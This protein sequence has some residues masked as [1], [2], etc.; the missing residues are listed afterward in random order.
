VSYVLLSL[1]IPFF[2]PAGPEA[3]KEGNFRWL[4]DRRPPPTLGQSPIGFHPF[5]V[6]DY[7]PPS[8]RLPRNRILSDLE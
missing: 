5:P 1:G 3:A 4:W 8:W 2:C 6:P 7:A